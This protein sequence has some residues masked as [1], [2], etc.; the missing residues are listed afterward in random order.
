MSRNPLFDA[1]LVYQNNESVKVQLGDSEAKGIE[2]KSTIAKFDMTFNIMKIE[3]KYDIGF[4]YCTDLFKGETAERIL[5]HFIEVLKA[6]TEN[7]EQKLGEI[8]MMTAEEKHLILNDFN[9]T[10]TDYPRDKTVVELFEEQ[11]KKTHDNTAVI[12]EDKKLTYAELNARANC[13]AHRLREMGVKPDDF[14]AIIA[15]R[16]IEMICGIYGIIT[17]RLRRGRCL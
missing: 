5:K 15:D 17:G 10:E 4:E 16:S 2:I 13:L 8:E 12:F 3:E 11:V 7:S 14:V 1:T 6:V 9:A